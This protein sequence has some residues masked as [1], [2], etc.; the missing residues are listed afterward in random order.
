MIEMVTVW[1]S[2]ATNSHM[3]RHIAWLDQLMIEF[4]YILS[5]SSRTAALLLEKE[6]TE[7]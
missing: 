3:T 2:L 5:F 1:K 7:M 4:A 6:Q